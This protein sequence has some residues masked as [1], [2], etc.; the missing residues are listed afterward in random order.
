MISSICWWRLKFKHQSVFSGHNRK[1][2]DCFGVRIKELVACSCSRQRKLTTYRLTLWEQ[3]CRTK[4]ILRYAS[5]LVCI[6]LNVLPVPEYYIISHYTTVQTHAK[7]ADVL[8]LGL[9]WGI[10]RERRNVWLGTHIFAKLT[11]YSLCHYFFCTHR[12]SAPYFSSVLLKLWV[13]SF[14]WRCYP[15]VIS[16]NVGALRFMPGF[17]CKL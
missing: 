3:L 13:F 1:W 10:R 17:A 7:C 4:R 9:A 6:Y 11:H 16:Y 2:S 14:A 5:L 8:K 12:T 15:N